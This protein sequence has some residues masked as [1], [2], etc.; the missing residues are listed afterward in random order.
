MSPE[1]THEAL[2]RAIL[3]LRDS[4]G[5]LIDAAKKALAILQRAA[6]VNADVRPLMV[7]MTP[8][9]HAALERLTSMITNDVGPGEVA[10]H[11]IVND[12]ATHYGFDLTPRME[13]MAQIDKET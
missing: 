8:E 2:H 7:V 6:L 5:P 11:T 3:S 9:E 4:E 13:P 1:E 10:R 12:L